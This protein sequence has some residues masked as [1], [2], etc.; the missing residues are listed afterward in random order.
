MCPT[1]Y[2]AVKPEQF[3]KEQNIH[4]IVNDINAILSSVLP[5]PQSFLSKLWN[6]LETEIR[7]TECDLYS[8]IPDPDADPFSE[9][10]NM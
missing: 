3:R 4:N 6:I 8:Y 5:E 7:V 10:G 1:Y 2:S 9:E